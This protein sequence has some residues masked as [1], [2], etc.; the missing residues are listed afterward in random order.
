MT[1]LY[2]FALFLHI[3]GGFGLMA[4]ITVETIGLRGLRQA[5]QRT[6]ALVWLGLS[7]SIVMRLTPSS[8][9]LI[10]V[11]GLYMVATVWGPRGWILVALGSLLLLGVI[12]A[13]GTGRRMARIGLAI[14][15]A[16]GPLP[17]ELREML[18]S[19]I[20]LM[21]L[22]VRLAIVLGVVFLMTLKPSAVASLAVIVLAVALGFLAGQI[23]ARR[24]RNELRADVG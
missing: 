9:G 12:G 24:G 8:L 22:R 5:T 13:F 18:G 16:H 17:A 14:G 4:A 2:Q 3:I 19:P 23:P 21:S 11:S 20:L 6:D 15:R 10:L 1:L 7:R